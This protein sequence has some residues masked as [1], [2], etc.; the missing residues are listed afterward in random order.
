MSKILYEFNSVIT[1]ND[2]LI[3]RVTYSM[4][5]RQDQSLQPYLDHLNIHL[6]FCDIL[7]F[8]L[9]HK[10]LTRMYVLGVKNKKNAVADEKPVS[11]YLA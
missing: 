7:I 9:Y 5:T 1:D 11:F 6:V 8:S 10:E 2:S 3:I 4:R